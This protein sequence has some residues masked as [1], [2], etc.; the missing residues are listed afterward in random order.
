LLCVNTQTYLVES[1][2]NLVL[3]NATI[4]NL[5][6]GVRYNFDIMANNNF[7]TSNPTN[8]FVIPANVPSAPMDISGISGNGKAIINWNEPNNNGSGIM[9]YNLYCVTLKETV[10]VYYPTNA[11]VFSDL[12]NN[13]SYSFKVTAVNNVGTSIDSSM[14]T[15]I[16]STSATFSKPGTPIGVSGISSSETVILSW[17]PPIFTGGDSL[18]NIN[19]NRK[20][21]EP[22]RSFNKN[23]ESD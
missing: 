22:T 5:T 16:P 10:T 2:F 23:L 1:S 8:V 21:V 3:H 7:G 12:S 13:T 11:Y 14:V 6:N 17:L 19:Y 15:I 9:Y 18:D 4:N 20:L